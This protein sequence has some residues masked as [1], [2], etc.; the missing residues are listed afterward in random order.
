MFIN[1]EKNVP[2]IGKSYDNPT[3]KIW[4]NEWT[5]NFCELFL[6]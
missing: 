5:T 1:L 3:S 4:V 6:N 2:I